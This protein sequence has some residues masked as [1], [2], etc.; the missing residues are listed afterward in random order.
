MPVTT[1]ASAERESDSLDQAED[2]E[3][4]EVGDQPA[5]AGAESSAV[6]GTGAAAGGAGEAISTPARLAARAIAA[7]RG[8]VGPTAASI[9]SSASSTFSEY[10]E[11]RASM[12]V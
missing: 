9:Q 10:S 6:Q 4:G 11:T 1:R 8:L 7:A 2:H 5:G 3:A 12:P